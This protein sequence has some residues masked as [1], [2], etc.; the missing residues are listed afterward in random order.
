MQRIHMVPFSLLFS[1]F[2]PSIPLLLQLF[3]VMMNILLKLQHTLGRKGM[4]NCLPLPR[5]FRAIPRVEQTA[6]YRHES[7][8]VLA[9]QEPVAVTVDLWDSVRIC[10]TDV[11][12]LQANK[13]SVLLVCFMNGEIAFP[14]P[15]LVQEP[16]ICP[17]GWEWRWNVA[18]LPVA[19]VREDVED[20]REEEYGVR[21]K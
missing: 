17:G 15:A 20:Y 12:R 19:D 7:I 9:F 14:E 6:S 1:A 21:R 8:I 5:M 3:K 16:K 18:N 13:F 10:D 4:R 11:M 2:R